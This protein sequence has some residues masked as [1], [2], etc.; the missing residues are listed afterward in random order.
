MMKNIS[1][2]LCSYFV[3]VLCLPGL[4]QMLHFSDC[5]VKLSLKTLMKALHLSFK[6][7]SQPTC[8]DI[9]KMQREGQGMLLKSPGVTRMNLPYLFFQSCSF[10]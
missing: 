8:H 1:S 3:F 9:S 4:L 5:L 10:E 2:V 7:T 6:T